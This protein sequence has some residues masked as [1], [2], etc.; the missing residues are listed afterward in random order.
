MVTLIF[1]LSMLFTSPSMTF[2]ITTDSR[3]K[4]ETNV[5]SENV[6]RKRVQNSASNARVETMQDEG[7][8]FS[9]LI[10]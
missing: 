10:R 1:F 3:V 4:S 7:K 6:N 5:Q 9:S 2:T 8:G